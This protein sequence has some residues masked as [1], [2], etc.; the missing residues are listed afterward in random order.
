MYSRRYIWKQA[1][2]EYAELG[3][4]H[5]LHDVLYAQNREGASFHK[6]PVPCPSPSRGVL[7]EAA[8]IDAAYSRREECLR[9]ECDGW[10]ECEVLY[11]PQRQLAKR[12]TTVF[13]VRVRQRRPH[14]RNRGFRMKAM[15]RG[16]T[17]QTQ[18]FAPG[19]FFISPVPFYFQAASKT[20]KTNKIRVIC[21][22]VQ[23]IGENGRSAS[24]PAAIYDFISSCANVAT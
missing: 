2:I 19:I 7:R 14:A 18:C 13:F 21:W 16:V 23:G 22:R 15:S 9:Y 17:K 4:C 6:S 20:V 8:N 3:G 24:L 12:E 5:L 1:L 11:K 10:E